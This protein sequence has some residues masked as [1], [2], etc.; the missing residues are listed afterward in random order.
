MNKRTIEFIKR[1][2]EIKKNSNLKSIKN[3]V[4]NLLIEI[5]KRIQDKFQI[6][7]IN[8]NP[9]NWIQTVQDRL[10]K[11]IRN[12]SN[13]VILQQPRFWAISITWSLI[14]G[15]LFGIAWI[16]IA[17]TDEIVI[18]TGKLEP[19]GGVIDV[20]MPV[21]GIAREV[22]VKE[23][24]LVEKGQLLIRL[25]TDMTETKNKALKQELKISQEIVNKLKYLVSEGA[26][27]EMQYL[28]QK[29]RV[30]QLKSQIETNNIILKYQEIISPSSGTIFELQ[31][32]G[33]GYVAKS[34]QPVL[35]IVPNKNLQA[36][37]EIDSRSIGFVKVGKKVEIS[38]D[39]YPSTDFGIV[40][41]EVI[42]VSSDALAPIPSEGKGYRFPADISI[43]TQYLKVKSGDKLPLQAGM[44]L[45]AN[46]KMRKVSYLKLLLNKFGD[47]ADSLKAI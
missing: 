22:L 40:E 9:S 15:T 25:D 17:K 45:S 3:N 18:A 7:D 27:S 2:K 38:I 26:V 31:P 23:G 44:S 42:K 30:E 16:C 14:G 21:E 39:S 34:S 43:T 24:E 11:K 37:V 1:I 32:K 13:E 46:I 8:I 33:P 20:Q 36:T 35:K 10:E 28:E 29:V 5:P 4:H 6:K 19:K 47:K 12:D 41:G